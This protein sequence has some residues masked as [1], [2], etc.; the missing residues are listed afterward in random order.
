MGKTAKNRFLDY[1]PA[2]FHTTAQTSSGML[3]PSGEGD[4]EGPFLAG[5]WQPFE[6]IFDEYEALLSTLD[7]YVAPELTP[8]EE[9]LPWLAAWV[10]LLLDEDRDESQRRRLIGDAVELYRWRGTQYGLK[11]YLQ[12]YTGLPEE[13][14]D[15]YEAQ[16]PAG[17][18]I[19]AA[20]QIWQSASTDSR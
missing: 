15:I 11:R 16:W 2:I 19:D 9:F 18:Q 7:R 1:L 6:Q 10:A 17:M 20:S 8:T 4:G 5:F 3:T 13:A 14:I 12:L